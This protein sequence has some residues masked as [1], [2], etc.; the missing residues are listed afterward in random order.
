M[1]YSNYFNPEET[2]DR[3]GIERLQEERLRR[4]VAHCMGSNFYRKR[5]SDIGLS[6]EDIKTLDDLQKF[7]ADAFVNAL[8]AEDQAS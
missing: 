8:F 7:D 5:F 3:E 6:P 4:T 1:A 2:L